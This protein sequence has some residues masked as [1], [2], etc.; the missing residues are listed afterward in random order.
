MKFNYKTFEIFVTNNNMN[1]AELKRYLSHLDPKSVLINGR[2]QDKSVDGKY[3]YLFNG[4]EKFRIGVNYL[5]GIAFLDPLLNEIKQTSAYKGYSDSMLLESSSKLDT[6][7]AQLFYYLLGI[8][9]FLDSEVQDENSDSLRI[10]LPPVKDFDDV[11]KVMNELKRAIS[12]PVSDEAI[13]GRVEIE[14]AESGSIWLLIALGTPVALRLI[15]ELCWAA[16]VIERKERENEFIAQQVKEYS[17]D[18]ELKES[19]LQ[20][21]KKL[22]NDLVESQAINIQ[23][24]LYNNREHEQTQRLILSITTISDLYH[25]GAEFHPALSAPE[26]VSNLFPNTKNQEL[27]ES[28]I[29]QIGQGSI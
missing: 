20:A 21:Q 4:L 11:A 15:G 26:S 16:K 18:N 28:K 19:L 2:I 17:L 8:N 23:Q 24:Q 10:K 5:S 12:I 6:L 14:R 22:I 1:L 27:L 25:K 29:K 13:G 3:H 9:S 7:S